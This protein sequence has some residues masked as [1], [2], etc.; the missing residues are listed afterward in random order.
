MRTTAVIGVALVSLLLASTATVA[1]AEEQPAISVSPET[2]NIGLDFSGADVTIS[3]T[4]PEGADVVL[5][6]DGPLDSVK[7]SKKG[8]VMG[9][10]W[11][12]VDQAEVENMAAFH[13][14]RS[15]EPI[16]H[17]LSREQQVRLG[18]DPEASNTL[19]QAQAVNPDDESPVS[20]EKQAEFVTAL[21]DMY[22]KEGQYTPW[23]CYHEADAADCDAA[24]PTGAIIQPDHD[25]R[26]ETSLGLPADA[27]LGD[28]SV[29]THY[30][31]DGEVVMSDTAT[32][33]V[34]KVGAVDALGTM[35]Q[36]K[37][38]LYGAMSLAIAIAMGLAIGFVFGSRGGH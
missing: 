15:S 11:M 33:N 2:V 35:A 27:P 16:E 23:R 14:V 26:W 22:I 7:M 3:G 24:A 37:A 34:E 38:P 9:L 32:F 1:R 10:F 20:G 28:Y 4:T 8:K 19:G 18:V 17:L 12:T 36:D 29:Q 13:I 5:V 30:V 31:R 25:G 21:R 6:V